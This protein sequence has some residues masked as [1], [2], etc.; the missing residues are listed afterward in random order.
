[1]DSV[2][3]MTCNP[4]TQYTAAVPIAPTR[5]RA[6]K[7]VRPYSAERMPVRRTASAR[8]A[9]DRSSS[10]V[11]PN[12]FTSRAP[13]TLNRS[14][15]VAFIEA[16]RSICVRVMD[17][18]RRPTR[19]AGTMNSGSTTS[20]SSVSLQSRNA[21]AIRVVTRVIRLDATPP[22]VVVRARCAPMTSLLRR[23]VRAPVWVRVKN[24]MGMR[25]TWPNTATRRS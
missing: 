20:D 13:D 15:I 18:R 8:W 21:M 6:M 16:L 11:R 17:C 9:N 1:M 19:L 5:P 14:V 3:L 10:A 23:L 7:N 22:I 24:E 4:P 12:S 2:P 25:C